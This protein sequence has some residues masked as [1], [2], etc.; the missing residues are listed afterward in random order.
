MKKLIISATFVT[1]FVMFV[2]D[3]TVDDI[4]SKHITAMGGK[5]KMMSLKTVKMTGIFKG[6]QGG[7][8]GIAII[9]KHSIGFRQEQTG[10]GNTFV[11]IVTQSKNWGFRLGQTA[12]EGKDEVY[13]KATKNQLDM[14]GPFISYKEK[15]TKIELAGK[16]ILDGIPCYNLKIIFK[17][18]TDLSYNIHTKKIYL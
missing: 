17:D 14:S 10:N 11:G 5:E 12:T 16:V 18:G 8:F 2:R 7:E 1:V 13:F 3:Q 9:K 15:G 6:G 4:I